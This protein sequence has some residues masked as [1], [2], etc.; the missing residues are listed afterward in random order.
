VTMPDMSI[1]ELARLWARKDSLSR[2]S[3]QPVSQMHQG[4]IQ[5]VG[6][7][8][9][10]CSVTINGGSSVVPGVPL[11]QPYSAVYPP[12]VGH[13]CWIQQVGKTAVILGQHVVAGVGSG[14]ITIP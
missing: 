4:V 10:S 13:T 7:G 5:A 1:D 3:P 9:T 12:H 6:G 8:G 2:V 14:Y 11:L